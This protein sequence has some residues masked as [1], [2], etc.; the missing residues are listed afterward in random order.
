[1]D[2]RYERRDHMTGN[3]LYSAV[4]ALG[5][6]TSLEFDDNFYTAANIA[7]LTVSRIAPEKRYIALEKV[8]GSGEKYDVAL[9]TD[10]F[11][12]FTDDPIKELVRGRDYRI[13]SGGR[14]TFIKRLDGE[15][16]TVEYK[17]QPSHLNADNMEDSIDVLPSLSDLIILLTAF[18]VLLDDDPDKAMLYFT[19]Y[20]EQAEK[21]VR[22]KRDAS[23]ERVLNIT[24]W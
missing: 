20:S 18:Y 15:D 12:G 21:A 11:A 22:G 10:D 2:M 23:Y 19:R 5:Y 17:H 9:L 1:M 14:I 16:L 7:I 13:E 4:S 3:E 6:Q 8:S 24:G